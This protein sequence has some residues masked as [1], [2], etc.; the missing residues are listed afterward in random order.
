M[1]DKERPSAPPIKGPRL[2]ARWLVAAG[3]IKL[4]VQAPHDWK[5][6][7]TTLAPE[8][9]IR[10]TGLRTGLSKTFQGK[11]LRAVGWLGGRSNEPRVVRSVFEASVRPKGFAFEEHKATTSFL[12]LSS[13]FSFPSVPVRLLPMFNKGGGGGR[14]FRFWVVTLTNA[15]RTFV[16]KALRQGPDALLVCGPRHPSTF[17]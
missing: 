1:R 2:L 4:G 14:S 12:S 13:F 6:F 7:A 9:R 5:T 3:A 11:T 10:V 15:E 8:K 16:T 17:Y